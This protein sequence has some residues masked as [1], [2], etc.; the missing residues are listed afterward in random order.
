MKKLLLSLSLVV[1]SLSA[2]AAVDNS[3]DINVAA[4]VVRQCEVDLGG[5]AGAQA[6]VAKE[7]TLQL[8]LRATSGND[9]IDVPVFESCN[10]DYQ[11]NL[12]SENGG[13]LSDKG[14]LIDYSV[15]YNAELDSNASALK[16]AMSSLP[17]TID[18][19][20]RTPRFEEKQLELSFA[21]SSSYP[22]GEY[23]D[24]ITIEMATKD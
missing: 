23:A 3:I 4:D 9:V 11:I 7:V 15:K 2:K 14:A 18:L 10:E 20:A 16:V 13:M 1:A 5:A 22:R 21:Q 12:K 19:S 17:R 6:S 24:K 8:P